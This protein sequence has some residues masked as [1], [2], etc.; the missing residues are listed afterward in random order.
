M[1]GA[2][3]PGSDAPLAAPDPAWSLMTGTLTRY[4][5]LAINIAMGIVLMPF[6]VRHLGIAE[7]GL[8]M[9]VASMTYL[10]PIAR[11]RLRKRRRAASRR[12]GCAP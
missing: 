7:Y 4:V 11:P 3:V 2:D 12:G 10:L 6:T 5:L 9:L 8:W 1:N